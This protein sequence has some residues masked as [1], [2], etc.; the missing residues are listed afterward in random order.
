M[1]H[2]C[3]FADIDT[4]GKPELVIG[5]YD[6]HVYVFNGEDGS[7]LWEY[8]APFYIG[9]PTSIGDLNN[10]GYFEIVFTSY[11]ILGVLSHSG[12]LLWSVT[13]GGDLFRGAALSDIDGDGILDVVF[14]SYDG[15]LRALKGDDG[16][17]IW[18]YD[19]KAHYGN[20]FEMDHAPVIADF[21]NDG[22]LDVFIVGGYGSSDPPTNNHGR[23]YAL[24][25]GDG[26]GPGWPMF[27]HDCLHS[28]LFSNF[29]ESTTYNR[30]HYRSCVWATRG[31][32]HVLYHVTDP[33]GD[34]VFCLWD[35]G[36]GTE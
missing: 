7:L 14:G 30:E 27:R 2:G 29:F 18:T 36:D 3:S 32:L 4:D 10:D 20:V 12:S 15:I 24:T 19:L 6:N 34:K 31:E 22:K 5:S 11:N 13:T 16:Q 28:G 26:S 17:I 25:A 33:E 35:W 23:A 1:Y 9:A 8:I 21:N